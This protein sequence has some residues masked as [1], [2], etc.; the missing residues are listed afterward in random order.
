[1]YI[2]LLKPPYPPDFRADWHVC[3]R[4]AA[5]ACRGGARRVLFGTIARKIA[6]SVATSRIWSRIHANPV[7]RRLGSPCSG[8]ATFTASASKAWSYF[9]LCRSAPAWGRVG[10][11]GNRGAVTSPP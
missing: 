7:S 8:E 5:A 9:S 4:V 11:Q 1:M 10:N 2:L 3:Y 6:A